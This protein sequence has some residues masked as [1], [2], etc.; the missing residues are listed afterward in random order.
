MQETFDLVYSWRQFLDEYVADNNVPYDIILM[1]E[2]YAS[3]EDTMRYYKD[4][5]GRKGAHMPFN[6]QLI[7]NFY[8]DA[9]A[10]NIKNGIF[11]WL[12]HMLEGET[13]D[14]VAGSHD[15]S[16]VASR[17]G[18]EK[19]H[20]VNTV[21]LSLPGASVT[22]YGEEIGMQDYRQFTI[23]DGRDPN[24][25]PMQWN[26]GIGAGFTTRNANETWL[27]IHPNYVSNNVQAQ[28]EQQRSTYKY[29]QSLTTIRKTEAFRDG[30]FN[31]AVVNENVLAFTR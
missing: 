5:D 13:A 22:Y 3:T 1:T 17:V 4:S 26:S 23:N 14:W 15:H 31:L 16:R 24:R 12:D 21:V 8:R 7:F 10:E 2:A 28:R 6:F 18:I 30:D 19:V 27:P 25:T 20:M 9:K 11:E 29:F